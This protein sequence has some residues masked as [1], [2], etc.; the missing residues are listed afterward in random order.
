LIT[1]API[2]NIESVDWAILQPRS[3]PSKKLQHRKG[4]FEL[5]YPSKFVVE[6]ENGQN[7][8]QVSTLQEL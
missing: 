5:R 7:V 2:H 3:S 4:Q 8:A 1:I 6:G